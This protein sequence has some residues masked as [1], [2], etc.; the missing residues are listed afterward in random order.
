VLGALSLGYLFGAFEEVAGRGFK[1]VDGDF[2][3]NFR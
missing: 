1:I 3:E 2:E